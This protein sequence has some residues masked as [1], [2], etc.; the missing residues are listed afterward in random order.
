LSI[1]CEL[2]FNA[3]AHVLKEMVKY[4]FLSEMVKMNNNSNFG[5]LTIF[6]ILEEMKLVNFGVHINW[7][8]GK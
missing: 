6:V 2:E 5:K 8:V 4:G 3:I 7:G 1:Y